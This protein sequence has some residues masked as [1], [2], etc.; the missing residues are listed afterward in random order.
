MFGHIPIFWMMTTFMVGSFIF[1][2]ALSMVRNRKRIQNMEAEAQALGFTFTAWN[3][4][5]S[6]P[7]FETPFFS[8]G[9]HSYKNMMTGSYAGMEV[10]VFD[11]SHTS[12][13][14]S[15]SSTSVQTIA[16]Y[17]RSVDL[18]VFA[19][20]PGGLAAKI[21][22]ALEHQNV[23]VTTDK[24]FSRHHSVRGSDKERIKALFNDRV[25]SFVKELDREKAWQI[26]GAGKA[27]VIYRYARRVKPSGLR[28]FLQ[29]TSSIAQSFFAYA[30][31]T[32]PDAFAASPKL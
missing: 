15:N 25:I 21:I 7:K 13:G 11:Y 3:N 2:I 5:A 1:S 32:K 27:L 23:E 4:A 10:Q 16:A 31:T 26:E 29:E 28:D 24:E 14:A 19:L 12:G 18:P 8:G 30:G 22:D 17:T 6:A 9:S 20:G